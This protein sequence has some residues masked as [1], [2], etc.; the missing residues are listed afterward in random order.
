MWR[1]YVVQS[2][3]II[4][5]LLHDLNGCVHTVLDVRLDIGRDGEIVPAEN[6]ETNLEE[7]LS[8]GVVEVFCRW[9][10]VVKCQ[11]NSHVC[12]VVAGC[13]LELA[14]FEVPFRTGF[15]WTLT[16]AGALDFRV[17]DVAS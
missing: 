11:V 8:N 15:G 1:S 16:S 5:A 4:C 14:A 17:V 9:V 3:G 2:V 12:L 13:D 10:V 7:W 6:P